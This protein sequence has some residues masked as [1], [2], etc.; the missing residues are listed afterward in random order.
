MTYEAFT[1]IAAPF[2]FTDTYASK[3][4]PALILSSHEHFNDKT[5]HSVMAMITSARNRHWPLDVVI[6]D[7]ADAGLP[8]PS[9]V[10]MK[11]FT[12]DHR[13]ITKVVGTLSKKD[14]AAV[15]KHLKMLLDH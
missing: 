15:K 11:L 4:R 12:L 1:I 14:Q 13:V 9:V 2:P 5:G 6:D 7:Y 10:R 3:L 8:N